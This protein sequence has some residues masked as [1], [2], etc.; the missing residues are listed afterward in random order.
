MIDK[1]SNI[2]WFNLLLI[3][4]GGLILLFIIGPL[5][6][7]FM[8]STGRDIFLTI[9]EEEVRESMI[10]T[11]LISFITTFIFSLFAVP[12]AFLLARKEFPLKKVIL[13]LIDLPVIIPHTAAGIAVL[14]VISRDTLVGRMA[15]FMGI[16][17]VNHPSGI[18]LAMAFVSIP[19]LINAA[20]D[21]FLNIP[22]QY[23]DAALNLGAS[24]FHV[25][26][27]ISLPLA[28]RNIISGFILM[29][30]RGMSEFGA[31]VI[32]AYHPMVTPILIFERFTQFGLSYARPVAVLFILICLLIFIMLRW[33]SPASKN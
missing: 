20:R 13:G 27:T 29:F 4:L 10:R 3:L 17:F 16:Q 2:N 12:F 25:F 5:A 22:K 33:L 21:G 23:E 31:V 14:G 19:F 28:W 24:P 18:G 26:F 1:K 15:E 32:I 11:L 6:S 8:H 9:G 30:G 7:M